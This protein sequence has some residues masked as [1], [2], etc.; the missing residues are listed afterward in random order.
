MRYFTPDTPAVN[1]ENILN[2]LR[3]NPL[4]CGAIA[5]ALETTRGHVLRHLRPLVSSGRLYYVRAADL[6]GAPG[7][8][9]E[10]LYSHTLPAYALPIPHTGTQTRTIHRSTVLDLLLTQDG[11][12]MSVET[13][14]ARL[15]CTPDAAR[16]TLEVLVDD[17][18]IRRASDDEY[19]AYDTGP[20]VV[21]LPP[22]TP[23]ERVYAQVAAGRQAVK[24]IV[25]GAQMKPNAVRHHL[26]ELYAEGAVTRTTSPHFR[27]HHYEIADPNTPT[28]AK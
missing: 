17:R 2:L 26:R 21:L 22:P 20:P 19:E 14:A 25:N 11:H 9:S 5:H 12:P 16:G 15:H 23:K 4:S 28:E 27:A 3:N 1:A 8:T 10:A 7:T 18:F 24:L 13:V 6:P